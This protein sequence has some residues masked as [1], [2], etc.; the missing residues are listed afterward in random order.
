MKRRPG[1]VAMATAQGSTIVVGLTK[2]W[3]SLLG[4]DSIVWWIDRMIKLDMKIRIGI[5]LE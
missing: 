5:V 1:A 2:G 4:R 3:F